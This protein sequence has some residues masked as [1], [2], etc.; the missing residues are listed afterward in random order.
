MLNGMS[1]SM[2]IT[3]FVIAIIAAYVAQ[4]HSPLRLAGDSPVYLCDAADLVDGKAAVF[5][6]KS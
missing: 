2:A 5:L 6:F 4:I 3:G 1:R